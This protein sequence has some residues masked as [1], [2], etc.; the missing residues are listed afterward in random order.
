MKSGG[1]LTADRDGRDDATTAPTPDTLTFF[2][3][4]EDGVVTVDG[5]VVVVVRGMCTVC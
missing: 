1:T 3:D 5:V 4:D 2:D